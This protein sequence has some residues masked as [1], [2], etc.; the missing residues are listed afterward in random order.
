MGRRAAAALDPIRTSAAAESKEAALV[1]AAARKALA[2]G[3]AAEARSLFLDARALR[4]ESELEDEE[5]QQ[6][7][8]EQGVEGLLGPALDEQ[9]LPDDDQGAPGEYHDASS[10]CR[11]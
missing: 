10:A 6:R 8:K 7:E 11:A 2:E 4:P 3:K 5:E 9:V 1:L